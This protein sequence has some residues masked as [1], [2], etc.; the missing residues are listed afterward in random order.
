MRRYDTTG[1]SRPHEVATGYQHASR[2]DVPLQRTADTT[3]TLT[4]L[5]LALI[6]FAAFGM[7]FVS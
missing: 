4:K 3:P 1:N 5:G 7:W 2:F 6:A